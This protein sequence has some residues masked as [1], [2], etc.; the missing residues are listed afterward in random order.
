M[1]TLK[2]EIKENSAG[3]NRNSETCNRLSD[4]LGRF[5]SSIESKLARMTLS[6]DF[7]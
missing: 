7:K 2:D 3:M 6:Y 4:E 5:R 1:M